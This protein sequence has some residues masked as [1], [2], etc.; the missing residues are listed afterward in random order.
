MK[1]RREYSAKET[2]LNQPNEPRWSTQKDENKIKDDHFFL[3]IAT[4]TQL[5]VRLNSH[6]LIN[7]LTIEKKRAKEGVY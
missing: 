5:S 1:S 3:E 2:R 6:L 4:H 7:L